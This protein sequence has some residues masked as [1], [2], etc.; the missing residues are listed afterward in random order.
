MA[1]DTA[2]GPKLGTYICTGCGLG[3]S[4][5]I[6]KLEEIASKEHKAPVCK[7]HPFFCSE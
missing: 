4:L 5:D 1:T 3:E 6:A 2:A 7:T